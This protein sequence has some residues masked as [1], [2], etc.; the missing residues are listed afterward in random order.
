MDPDSRGPMDPQ[1]AKQRGRIDYGKLTGD[2]GGIECQRR[3]ANRRYG[4]RFRFAA[5]TNGG[6][7]S[8]G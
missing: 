5:I 1:A 8:Y 2:V 6:L 7:S 4:T 3:M